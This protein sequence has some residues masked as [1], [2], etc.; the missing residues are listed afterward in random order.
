MHGG[1]PGLRAILALVGLGVV[2]TALAF[3]IFYA[4]DRARSARAAPRWSATWRPGVALFYGAV[5]LDEDVG[6]AAVAGLVLILGG[7]GIAGRR[8]AVPAPEPTLDT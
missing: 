5:F 3:V 4:A 7:V 8:R 2:G 1:T 6:L